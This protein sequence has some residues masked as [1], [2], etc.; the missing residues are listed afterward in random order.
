[1]ELMTYL[2][3]AELI[4]LL[5][6]AKSK[7][8][9]A[10]CIFYICY[11]LGLRISECIGLKLNDVDFDEGTIIVRRLKGSNMTRNTL[12][13]ELRL[14]LHYWKKKSK[15]TFFFDDLNRMWCDRALKKLGTLSHIKRKKLHMHSLK[16]SCAVHM[17]EGG[18]DVRT[19]QKALGHKN[20]NNTIRY[21]DISNDKVNRVQSALDELL[22]VKAE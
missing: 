15:G 19:I 8:Y 17:L 7:N 20:I 6:V 14:I 21:L 4:R 10:Y 11:I 12:T 1:M 22:G 3:R 13:N 9:K 18:V 5:K 2:T 16:H